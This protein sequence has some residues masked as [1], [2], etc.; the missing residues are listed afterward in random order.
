[1]AQMKDNVDTPRGLAF[2]IAAYVL[3]GFL[4]LYMKALSHVLPAEVVVH[5]VIWSV[6][7]AGVVL[8]V[9]GRTRELR[10]AFAH[11]RML[12]QAALTAALISVNWGIYIWSIA[13]GQALEAALGYYINPLFSIFLGAVLLGERLNRVQMI[14][15]SF[16]AAAVVILTLEAGR[17]PLVA[18]GLMI[19]WGFYAYFKKS[20]P[21]GPNQGF[22]LEVLILTPFALAYMA[23]LGA[24]GEGV[25]LSDAPTTLLLLAAGV[26]TAV[27]LLLYA[28]GAKGVRMSTVGILQYIA[29]TM[30]FL[31][32]VFHF[33]EP[34]SGMRLFAFPLIWLALVIYTVPML[35]SLK[36]S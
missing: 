18:V 27:P 14:A 29:P 19:T 1:M 21:I 26:V 22:L 35:R 9:M 30:I 11:P 25:F 32:A 8:I 31:I 34:L 24:T 4:P 17:L 13:N 20:L 12:A 6:P 2:V 23:Y 3:W 36:R 28:N 15:I 10:E 33:G 16:A 7:V 5:R